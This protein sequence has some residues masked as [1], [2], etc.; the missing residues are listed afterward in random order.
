MG[1]KKICLE[2]KLTF[3]RPIDFGSGQT[4]PCPECAKPM[5]LLPHRFRPP[6]K[7]NDKK[8]ETV[9]F[10]IEHGFCY[11]HIYKNIETKNGIV[12]NENYVD[13]PENLKDAKEFIEKYKEQAL[14]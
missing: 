4:Y 7:T 2:C 11:Q 9:K 10:L 12:I 6:K 8:W 5:T 14:K 3:N 13:Y 1:Y